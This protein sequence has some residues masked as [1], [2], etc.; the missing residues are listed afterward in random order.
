[1]IQSIYRSVHLVGC[2]LDSPLTEE[3][4]QIVMKFTSDL[5]RFRR[6]NVTEDPHIDADL[7]E[8]EFGGSGD[9][10][11]EELLEFVSSRGDHHEEKGRQE[12]NGEKNGEDTEEIPRGQIEKYCNE[13]EQ[14]FSFYCV[15]EQGDH[16]GDEESSDLT[17]WPSDPFTKEVKIPLTK[18]P[19]SDEE[20]DSEEEISSAEDVQQRFEALMGELKRRIPCTPTCDRRVYPHC[21]DECKCDYIYPAVQHFC[22]PPPLPLFLNTC[23]LWYHFCPKYHQYHYASQYIYSKAEKGKSWPGPQPSN[24]NPFNIPSPAG[25]PHVGTPS[26]VA[27]LRTRSGTGKRRDRLKLG[28]GLKSTKKK[29]SA[30]RAPKR[31]TRKSQPVKRLSTRELFRTL[32]AINSLTAQP[33]TVSNDRDTP[34]S[35]SVLPHTSELRPRAYQAT[36]PSVVS[37]DRQQFEDDTFRAFYYATDT[38]GIYHRPRSRGPWT[39]PGLWEANPDNPHNRDHANKWWY[40]PY[41][42]T[43]DWLNGQVTWGA[44]FAVPAAGVGGSDGYSA[45]FFPSVGT[46]LNIPDDYD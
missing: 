45:L 22:N 3:E 25:V 31:K 2:L 1:M 6:N 32:K 14:H 10:N 39:K 41:S 43:A 17:I 38:H 29:K 8:K 33:L 12:E 28:S 18:E 24:P 30:K 20:D 26:R 5:D 4:R 37:P 23:R 36:K 13:Y 11:E 42:V 27:G 19:E 35:G 21:T 46:F 15:G 34:S 40:R 16:K 44:H 7:R 9:N